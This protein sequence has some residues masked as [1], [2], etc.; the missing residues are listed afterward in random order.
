MNNIEVEVKSFLSTEQ[1]QR[2]L[3][4]FRKEAGASTE[5][6]QETYYFD[7]PQDIRI[8]RNSKFSKI[9]FKSG[10][11]HD[12]Q[13]EEIEIKCSRDDFE[14]LEGIFVALGFHVKIKWF[15]KRYE[16]Q[17]QGVTATVDST[18]GYGCILELDTIANEETKDAALAHLNMLLA[19]LHMEKTPREE[20]E[21]RYKHYVEHWQELTR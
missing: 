9:T 5:D 4:F 21:K 18:R 3:E 12:E 14:K 2:L 10:K 6:F 19:K 15:R 1:Y 13:R 20:F 8:Q 7:A 17:W 11:V 16:F